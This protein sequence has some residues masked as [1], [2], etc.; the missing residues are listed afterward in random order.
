LSG[1]DG[2]EDENRLWWPLGRLVRVKLAVAAAALVPVEVRVGEA[3]ATTRRTE[4]G[5]IFKCLKFGNTSTRR[6]H[7]GSQL[8]TETGY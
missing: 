6:H 1:L 3:V 7:S 5:S 8:R 4:E 2:F